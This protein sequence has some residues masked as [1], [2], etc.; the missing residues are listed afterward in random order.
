MDYPWRDAEKLREL[1]H[2]EGLSQHEI[3]DRLDTH[4]ATINEWMQRHGIEARDKPEANRLANKSDDPWK[5]PDTL[6]ELYVERRLTQPEI[7]E[8]LGCGDSTVSN[9]I[10]R[11]GIKLPWQDETLMRELYEI[12][13]LSQTEIADHLDC[14]VATVEK[15]LAKH[16]I[17]G[18]SNGKS[19]QLSTLPEAAYKTLTDKDEVEFLYVEQ[20][21]STRE[22]AE[23][24][25]VSSSTAARYVSEY[26]FSDG[27]VSGEDHPMW[28]GGQYYYYGPNWTEQREKR[29]EKDDY[30]CVVCGVNED[31]YLEKTGR[32]LD[33][34]HITPRRKFIEDGELDYESANRLNNLITM[35]RSCHMRWEDIG[36]KPMK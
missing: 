13:Q 7:A 18:R 30:Q 4:A 2:G 3:A 36:L 25:G 12:E 22:M 26:G 34:H 8:K 21:H 19:V 16:D 24:L 11:L 1:Y 10:N 23:M 9:W 15:W 6:H 28:K 27:Q 35:C 20:G 17:D 29:L 33:V 31:E 14:G 5:D 32:T